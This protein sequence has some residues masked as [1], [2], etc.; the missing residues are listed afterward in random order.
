[1][2][3]ANLKEISGVNFNWLYILKPTKL[4]AAE[5]K[6]RFNFTDLD[7]TDMLPPIQ[8][9]K[10]T[11][12]P[13]YLFLTLLFPVYN[14][15]TRRVRP[16]EVDFFIGQNFLVS[17][18]N[19]ALWPLDDFFSRAATGKKNAVSFLSAAP[20]E[21]LI[22]IL[23]RLEK[24]CHPMLV[25]VADDI[26]KVEAQIFLESKKETL[27]AINETLLIKTNIVNFRKAMNR[28][29][30]V[31]HRLSEKL[32]H[33]FPGADHAVSFKNIIDQAD[34]TWSLLEEYTSTINA[35]H[36]THSSLL[37]VRA[38]SVMQTFTIFTTLIFASSLIVDLL[39]LRQV[40]FWTIVAAIILASALM[41]LYFRQRRWW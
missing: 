41:L 1:M 27:Q 34:D 9:P 21:L 22:A 36:S 6:R 13:D 35:L 3:K 26:E 28:H 25:H 15:Q 40:S 11:A 33:F 38:N 4:E 29:V 10:L 23:E 12:N 32:Q 7:L 39:V 17:S 5:L 18:S 16:V 19:E 24:Y 30:T 20:L 14:R 31:I 2:T 37:N 8:R